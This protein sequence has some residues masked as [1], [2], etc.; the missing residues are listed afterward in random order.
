MAILK[1][2]GNCNLWCDYGG[3]LGKCSTP[4]GVPGPKKFEN[5]WSKTCETVTAEP[6]GSGVNW[7]VGRKQPSLVKRCFPLSHASPSPRNSRRLLGGT[8]A[9]EPAARGHCWPLAAACDG[10]G[11]GWLAG[12]GCLSK[13][14][15]GLA[16]SLIQGLWSA[17]LY[18]AGDARETVM[19][20]PIGSGFNWDTWS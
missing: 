10:G 20:E 16:R 8:S 6:V 17:C 14:N 9:H 15:E 7:G 13:G 1:N 11:R 4:L 18:V 3:I 19:A 5:P 12:R 2:C